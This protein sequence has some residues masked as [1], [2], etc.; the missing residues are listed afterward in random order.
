M[1]QFLQLFLF[2]EKR[3]LN[4]NY[5]LERGSDQTK[6]YKRKNK[7][8]HPISDNEISFKLFQAFYNATPS[9]F[10]INTMNNETKKLSPEKK[11]CKRNKLT[12]QGKNG[13]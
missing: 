7:M 5:F 13:V 12:C 9:A 2:G 4:Q 10:I 8:S 3:V 11:N 6:K 1:M